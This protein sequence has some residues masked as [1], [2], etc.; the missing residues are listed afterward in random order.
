[1]ADS[2][3][4]NSDTT[5]IYKKSENLEFL[6]ELKNLLK[7]IESH[8]T[9]DEKESIKKELIEKMNT[10]LN[11]TDIKLEKNS[12]NGHIKKYSNLIH[13]DFIKFLKKTKIEFFKKTKNRLDIENGKPNQGLITAIN[14]LSEFINK[15]KECLSKNTGLTSLLGIQSTLGLLINELDGVLSKFLQTNQYT[16]KCSNSPCVSE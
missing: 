15:N 12:S 7:K 9:S 10:V 5:S 1:M 16:E 6:E 3:E 13:I 2:N 11:I 8:A 14:Q 4:S